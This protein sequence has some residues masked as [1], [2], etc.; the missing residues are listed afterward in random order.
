MLRKKKKKGTGQMVPNMHGFLI[1]E[2][3]CE[4]AGPTRGDWPMPGFVAKRATRLPKKTKG[5]L[6]KNLPFKWQLSDHQ[7][8]GLREN[9]QETID[10]PIK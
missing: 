9:L 1:T 2:S 7:W 6:L 5:G 10:F 8:I 3:R 4:F